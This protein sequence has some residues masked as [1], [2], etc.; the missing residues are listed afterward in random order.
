MR[1]AGKVGCDYQ[2]KMNRD[3]QKDYKPPVGK[4]LE[5]MAWKVSLLTSPV[6]HSFLKLQY[7]FFISMGVNL[8]VSIIDGPSH[9]AYPVASHSPGMLLGQYLWGSSKSR[10]VDSVEYIMVLLYSRQYSFWDILRYNYIADITHCG[11]YYGIT[12]QQILLT[13]GYIMILL[14]SRYYLLW[15]I[16]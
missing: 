7:I 9:N 3:N 15:D 4:N 10:V 6:G 11:I 12:I 14:Y 16:L 2:E 8:S 13:V 5:Q 1:V